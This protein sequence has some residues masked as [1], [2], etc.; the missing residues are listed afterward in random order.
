MCVDLGRVKSKYDCALA[1]NLHPEVPV[2][3]HV[4]VKRVRAWV[5]AAG[6]ITA[7][8]GSNLMRFDA[9]PGNDLVAGEDG[10]GEDEILLLLHGAGDQLG[11][12]GE[13]DPAPRG[14]EAVIAVAQAA[15]E[16]R[17]LDQSGAQDG[18]RTVE[19]GVGGVPAGKLCG[20]HC[21]VAVGF[22]R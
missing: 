22:A 11:G 15:G 16:V 4:L 13:G 21:A 20:G 14:L 5:N 8:D 7:L 19:H 1:A 17:E 3:R 2:D 10:S 18:G 6:F 12:Q 9:G